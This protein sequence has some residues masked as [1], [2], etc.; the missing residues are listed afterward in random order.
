M[1]TIWIYRYRPMRVFITS[2][3][4]LIILVAPSCLETLG[5]GKEGV[6]TSYGENFAK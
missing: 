3:T 5:N 1:E 2:T 6:N 4:T